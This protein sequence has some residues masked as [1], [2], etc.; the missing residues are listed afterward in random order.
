MRFRTVLWVLLPGVGHI[1]IGCAGKG[2]LLFTLFALALNAWLIS[3]ILVASDAVR[4]SLLSVAVLFWLIAAVD[5][6]RDS[7]EAE[8]AAVEGRKS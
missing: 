8:L 7:A 2:L 4:I 1:H 5:Y 6:I 3:P